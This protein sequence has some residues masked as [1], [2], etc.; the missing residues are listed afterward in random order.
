M[1]L[2]LF[3]AALLLGAGPGLAGMSAALAA[4]LPAPMAIAAVD[5]KLAAVMP[6]EQLATEDFTLIA[7][8][9]T[10]VISSKLVPAA[11]GMPAYCDVSGFVQPQI[12]FE[13]R[14]P[15]HDWN[16][17]YFQ[18]GCGGLCGLINIQNCGDV[19]ARNFAVAADNMGHVSHF[20]K[21]PLWAE[22]PMLRRDYGGRGTHVTSIAAKAIIAR[23]Y[24]RVPAFAYFRGCSTGGREALFEAQH[25][26]ADFDGIISGDPAFAARLGP[27]NNNFNARYELHRD[28]TPVFTP[29]KLTLLAGAVMRTCD[30]LDGLKDGIIDDPRACHFNVDTLACPAADRADCLNA[31]QVD[32]AKHI[33]D[34]V[35]NSKGVRLF[36]G[37]EMFGSE[38]GWDG[39]NQKDIANSH[40]RY[41]GFAKNPSPTYT[42]WDF[43]FDRDMPK[44][45][46]TT[47]IYDPVAPYTA[48]D[49]SKFHALGHKLI[50]YHGWADQGISPSFTL[51]YYAKIYDASG[52]LQKTRDWMRVFMVPGMH[53][54]RGG[55]APNTFDFMPSLQAWSEHGEAPVQVVATQLK[56]GKVVRTRPLVPYPQVVRFTGQGDP[57]V[58]ANWLVK[59]PE[60]TYDD[61]V[62]YLWGPQRKKS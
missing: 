58:A 30:A 14:L 42:F 40:L 20:W 45:E 18:V 62:D 31:E 21:E 4:P 10:S 6:C 39:V 11:G 50:I 57:N 16:G 8:A 32:S 36:P 23:L 3:F 53:H 34:G 47:A 27:I 15:A 25:Y 37:G 2:K 13:L 61:N 60:K 28:G 41:L 7:D 12:G 1:R 19:L 44:L 56:D 9:P 33:Y 43:N 54:C 24:G 5:S 49:L 26:P 38:L 46:A 48:P 29:A 17:R 22:D 55:D 35:R 52:G 51:D 59:D